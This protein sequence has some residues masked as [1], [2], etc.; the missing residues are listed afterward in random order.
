MATRGS[1][2]LYSPP[3]SPSLTGP[4]SVRRSRPAHRREAPR[5]PGHHSCYVV[6]ASQRHTSI[7][8]IHQGRTRET[9]FD[10]RDGHYPHPG[11]AAPAARAR[12]RYRPAHQ[13]VCNG[14][15]NATTA[16]VR[17]RPHQAQTVVE[18]GVS[19]SIT[20][21]SFQRAGSQRGVMTT[22]PTAHSPVERHHRAPAGS[23][24]A[25]GVAFREESSR[26]HEYQRP[27]YGKGFCVGA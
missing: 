8:S 10:S 9:G 16:P 2:H 22:G 24:P 11:I 1:P 13:R 15:V 14:E 3:S 20:D 5:H 12:R 23:T 26:E 6:P 21:N 17:Y 25:L 27:H 4:A 19:S 7:R 18:C